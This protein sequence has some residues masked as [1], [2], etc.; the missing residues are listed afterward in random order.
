MGLSLDHVGPC[1]TTFNTMSPR[2][3]SVGFSAVLCRGL[4]DPGRALKTP[5]LSPEQT[6][7]HFLLFFQCTLE[8]CTPLLVRHPPPRSKCFCRLGGGGEGDHSLSHTNDP[9]KWVGGSRLFGSAV[10]AGP[11]PPFIACELRFALLRLLVGDRGTLLKKHFGQRPAVTVK[12]D[13]MDFH[14]LDRWRIAD[15]NPRLNSRSTKSG[16]DSRHF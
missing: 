9:L 7:H 1:G 8:V 16:P 12:T 4:G 13:R 14:V 6:L 15:A 10:G 5:N 2:R 3:A 11:A